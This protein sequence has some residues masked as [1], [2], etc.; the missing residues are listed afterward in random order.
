[1]KKEEYPYEGAC[2]SVVG[3]EVRA[4]ILRW[5]MDTPSERSRLRSW[6]EARYNAIKE[7]GGTLA[8]DLDLHMRLYCSRRDKWME[9]PGE[10]TWMLASHS[11]KAPSFYGF[12]SSDAAL[13]FCAD[14]GWKDSL[15]LC[16]G[17]EFEVPSS[18]S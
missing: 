4:G 2:F 15:M 7:G 5:A 17:H 9:T 10:G 16:L 8:T 18:G 14:E 6:Q 1:M 3:E 11:L 12:P 13:H